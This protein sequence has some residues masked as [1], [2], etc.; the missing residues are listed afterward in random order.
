MPLVIFICIN[1]NKILLVL[2]SD[3]YSVLFVCM[4]TS[5]FIAISSFF[6]VGIYFA[7]FPSIVLYCIVNYLLLH[8]IYILLLLLYLFII[9]SISIIILG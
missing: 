2:L 8:F 5:G 1:I 3:V 4:F 6:L 9:V 7:Y